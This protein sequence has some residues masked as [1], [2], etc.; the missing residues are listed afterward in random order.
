VEVGF[1]V[2]AGL[3]VYTYAAYPLLIQL[4]AKVRPWTVRRARFGG[5]VSVVVAAFNEQGSIH[6]R[7][8]ELAELVRASGL[9]GEV[10]V[11]SDGSTDG[12]AEL[13]RSA[14]AGFGEM[15]RVIELPKNAGKASALTA[16][17]ACAVGDVLVFADARQSWSPE[18]LDRLLE[19]FADPSVG[20]VSGELV[21][22]GEA[23]VMKGVG[24]Y[25]R[26]E[27]HLRRTE[28]RI[29]SVVGATGSISAVRRPLFRPIPHGT[30][31]DD[32][33]W[34]LHVVLQGKRVV[35]DERARASDQLPST[36]RGEFRRKVRT[37]SGNFQLVT[38][39]PAVLLP[40]R[41]RIWLQFVSHKLLRLVVPWALLAMLCASALLG[42]PIYTTA[43]VLQAVF[44]VTGIVGISGPG[45]RL[46]FVSAPASFVVLN[47]AAWVAFWV[48]VCGATTRSWAKTE[49]R[50]TAPAG[51][52]AV[53]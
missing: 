31:L 25:W 11:V 8:R 48:W 2:C 14:G 47:A 44:Y 4:V 34:P 26:Y 41:N 27:K 10:I 45:S 51:G 53:V 9:S 23:G 43:V 18:T 15:V 24:L 38:R 36:T 39:M 5:S 33:F 29:D 6:G 3:V 13:A 40:W 42:G 22:G 35:H 30:V 17:C 19:S 50:A 52:P 37:L 28:S 1:W 20:A 16:G 49:Y 46:R 7:T 21:L 32:V 12:T